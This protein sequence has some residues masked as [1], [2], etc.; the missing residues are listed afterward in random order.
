MIGRRRTRRAAAV[1]AASLLAGSIGLLAGCSTLGEGGEGSHGGNADQSTSAEA[2]TTSPVS[3]AERLAAQY[4]YAGARKL[5]A[6]DS[7]EAARQALAD[8]ERA[9]A[10]LQPW[11]DTTRVSHLFYHS[12]I[13]D[14][15][16]AFAEGEPRRVGYAQYMVTIG[17]FRAQ[18]EQIYQRGY[19]LVHPQRLVT[20]DAA[21]TLRRAKLLLPPG[22]TPLVLSVDDVNYYEYMTDSGFASN[23][24]VVNGRVTN[25]YRDAMGGDHLGSYDVPTIL[26]DFVREHPDF[27][28]HGDKGILAVTGYNGVL[29][30]RS[31]IR[32]Y[33]DTPHTRAQG[34]QAKL[35]ADALKADG[36]Q[37][38]SHTW[39]HIDLTTASLSR[40]QADA[41]RWDREVRPIVGATD[42]LVYPFGADISGMAEYTADNEKF[43]FLNGHE[44][45]EY[46]FPIDASTAAWSQLTRN[47]WRQA[48]INVDG[49]TMQREL[50]GHT[51]PLENFFTAAD[52][53][54]PQRPMP[55]PK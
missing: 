46:F 48:R 42:E 32:M 16:R 25:T 14:P 55:L 54:D 3:A 5:L 21:G 19:V 30:Y 35:V 53:I 27:S 40:I 29:G 33:G 13:V 1:I 43:A 23:L 39:G 37:F 11:P 12:L 49:I 26:D 15:A 51:T 31:S 44:G 7:S 34:Q 8:I 4:D 20:K 17:E 41:Q 50:D 2:D 28:F 6:H 24:T 36:W 10:L 45:F 47:S 38:A 18:I 22:K 52:T 9:Q